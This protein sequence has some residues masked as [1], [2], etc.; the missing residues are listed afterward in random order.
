[1]RKYRNGRSSAILITLIASATCIAV[2]SVAPIQ[3]QAPPAAGSPAARAAG[4][5]ADTLAESKLRAR[6]DLSL[7]DAKLKAK[8]A[9]VREA[10]LRIKRYQHQSVDLQRQRKKGISADAHVE[11]AELELARAEAERESRS[12]ELLDIRLRR[13]RVKRRLA[14]VEQGLPDWAIFEAERATNDD[15]IDRLRYEMDQIGR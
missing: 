2:I 1:M 9:Q 13:D 12:A 7:L 10:D 15:R 3:A 11:I 8:T 4:P 5:D 6:E 14:R